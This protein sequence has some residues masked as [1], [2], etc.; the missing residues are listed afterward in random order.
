MKQIY[1]I[2]LLALVPNSIYA[3]PIATP[4]I[5]KVSYSAIAGLL[6]YASDKGYNYY[7]KRCLRGSLEE[8]IQCRIQ[9]RA[10]L[11]KTSKNTK[12]YGKNLGPNSSKKVNLFVQMNTDPIPS[13]YEELVRFM[14][15]HNFDDRRER[16]ITTLRM[17]SQ[18]EALGSWYGFKHM[19]D[20]Q[21]QAIE[22]SADQS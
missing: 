9:T 22:N 2:T 7:S 17:Y 8:F 19:L 12:W 15:A 6:F 16:I 5:A 11:T 20:H 4:I 18:S 13:S 14:A 21:K 10:A 1:L 3:D